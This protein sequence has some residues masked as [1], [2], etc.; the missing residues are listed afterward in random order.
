MT[1]ADCVPDPVETRSLECGEYYLKS[2]ESKK[3]GLLDSVP[4]DNIL[5]K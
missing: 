2:A 3:K 4:R 1:D 5:Q